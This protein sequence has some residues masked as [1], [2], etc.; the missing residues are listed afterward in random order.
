MISLSEPNE[1]LPP[2]PQSVKPKDEKV[3]FFRASGADSCIDLHCNADAIPYFY[4]HGVNVLIADDSMT[5]CKIL[6]G[7][8]RKTHANILNAENGKVALE[9][10]NALISKNFKITN[11]CKWNGYPPILIFMDYNMPGLNGVDAISKIRDFEEEKRSQNPN[12]LPA[13]I[14][15][16]TLEQSR[17][18]KEAFIQAGCEGFI[19]KGPYVRAEIFNVLKKLFYHYRMHYHNIED[20]E[21]N[22]LEVKSQS[23]INQK[24]HTP[25]PEPMKHVRAR[26]F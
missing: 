20:R 25:D 13:L 5:N 3:P 9:I 19:T 11:T 10:Y 23:G 6:G 15:A 4:L 7:I 22:T 26:S 12:F 8:L 17:E 21:N 18:I 16:H 14:V 2:Q 1:A 24:R